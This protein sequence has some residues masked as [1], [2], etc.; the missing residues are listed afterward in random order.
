MEIN[1]L[2]IL[3]RNEKLIFLDYILEYTQQSFKE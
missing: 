3:T 2:S 1:D